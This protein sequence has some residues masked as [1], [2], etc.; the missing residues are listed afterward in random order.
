MSETLPITRAQQQANTRQRLLEVAEATFLEKG[1]YGSS[2]ALVSRRAGFS[3]GAL[4]SNF[5]SKET[6]VLEVMDRHVAEQAQ[7]LAVAVTTADSVRE[8]LTKVSAW[9]ADLLNDDPRWTAL[10]VEFTISAAGKPALARQLI[11]R[12]KLIRE[13]LAEILRQQADRFATSLALDAD[14]LAEAI[15]S[16]GDGLAV[17]K[18]L[19]QGSDAVAVFHRSLA[20]L[21][22]SEPPE[23]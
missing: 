12:Q 16:L 10:E 17:R 21:L 7:R 4:Y 19:D 9:F 2:V 3:T 8:V 20:L 5:A 15:L 11:H 1:Y 14:T 23:C 13:G 6:L 22:G 18:L